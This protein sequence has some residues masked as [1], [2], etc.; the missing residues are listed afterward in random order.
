MYFVVSVF[1]ISITSGAS[2]PARAASSLVRCVP[3][4]WYC[5]STS[6]P[7]CLPWKS[8]VAE[9]T[10]SGQPDWA[11]FWSQTVILFAAALEPRE[12]VLPAAV[13]AATASTTAQVAAARSR[14]LIS[15]LRRSRRPS[16]RSM[17]R[18]MVGE[19]RT[20]PDEPPIGLDHRPRAGEWHRPV[21]VS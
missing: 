4:V 11:S 21:R 9:A 13:E 15:T 10:I 12:D 8:F 6:T 17:H 5:T 14:I 7:G 2:P 16:R 3:H 1:P 18:C 19:D 20:L